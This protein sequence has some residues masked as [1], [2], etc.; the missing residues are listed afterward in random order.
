MA[1]SKYSK[2]D[3]NGKTKD[4]YLVSAEAINKYTGKRHQRKRRGITSRPKAE[5]IYK[6]IWNLCLNE[7]PSIPNPKYWINLKMLYF[8]FLEPKIRSKEN[9]NGLSPLTLKMKKGLLKKTSLW[10]KIHIELITPNFVQN[11]LTQK[12]KACE[13]SFNTYRK[14]FTEVKEVFQFAVEEGILQHNS[15]LGVKIK[16]KPSKQKKMA[17]THEEANLLLSEAKTQSHPYLFVWTMALATGMRRSELAGLKWTDIDFENGL[18]YV[19]KQRLPSEGLI[20][21]T[22]SGFDRTVALPDYLLPILKSEKLK[23]TSEF[24]I[25]LNCHK[26][27]S[28]HQARVT[29]AFCRKIGIKEIT[30]HQLR[31]THI[32]LAIVDNISLG[33]IKE[34]VGHS[35]LSTTDIYFRSSGI[36][37]KGKTNGLKLKIPTGDI[38][39]VVALN[40]LK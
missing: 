27:K 24:V 37:M 7:K 33:I 34:N 2:T 30:F 11:E 3:I 15:F 16:A 23:S 21:K 22:K 38:G 1:I 35:R 5:K 18:A 14:V 40:K 13:I 26:W 12:M 32:T 17:L 31:A 29:R 19:E 20:N 28:G 39:K 36:N 25:S 4:F 10:D 8:E 9:L 6:E